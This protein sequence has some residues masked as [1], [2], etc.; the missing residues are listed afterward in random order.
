M[1][2]YHGPF[3]T[4]AYTVSALYREFEKKSVYIIVSHFELYSRNSPCLYQVVEEY[5]VIRR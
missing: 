5:K 4:T 2:K 1:S 3:K